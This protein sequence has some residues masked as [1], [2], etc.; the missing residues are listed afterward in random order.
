MKLLGLIRDDPRLDQ[1]VDKN[2]KGFQR[3]LQ[4]LDV[5][6]NKSDGTQ[7]VVYTSSNMHQQEISHCCQDRGNCSSRDH[8]KSYLSDEVALIRVAPTLDTRSKYSGFDRHSAPL[9]LAFVAG[10][11]NVQQTP[12]LIRPCFLTKAT[13][14]C[15]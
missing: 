2:G 14:P 11:G 15:P 1:Q 4:I 3:L 9:G 6:R 5:N 12:P 7:A 8:W 10:D 13:G